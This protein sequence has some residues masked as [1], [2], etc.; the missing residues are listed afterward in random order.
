MRCEQARQLFNAYLDGELAP[1][2]ATELAAHRVQCPE[3]RRALAL[4]EV[5]GHIVASD[6]EPVSLRA[7]FSERLLECVDAQN[8]SWV[9]RAR[10]VLYLGGPLAA[11]AVIVLAF[12]GVWDR[13]HTEVAGVVQPPPVEM[14]DETSADTDRTAIELP[15]TGA[16]VAVDR[17]LE[18]WLERTKE[19]IKAKEESGESLKNHFDLTIWQLIDI[20]NSAKE[21]TSGE[22]HFPGADIQL[23]PATDESIRVDDEEVEDL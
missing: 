8:V 1:A 18:E 16:D 23:E 13:H 11:A 17:A 3:C 9:H 10:R 15:V 6:R 21:G 19:N 22:D 2:L 4:M 5:S 14:I 20:L 7:G 12:L